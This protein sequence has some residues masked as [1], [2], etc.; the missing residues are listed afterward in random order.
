MSLDNLQ[1]PEILIAELYKN[2]LV[3]LT[4]D[5]DSDST[6]AIPVKTELKDHLQYL[7]DHLKRTCILVNYPNDLYIAESQLT[8]LANVL[9]A[10]SLTLADIA[11]INLAKQQPSI[12]LI[13]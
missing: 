2:N 11:I 8:F 4:E 7:G 5:N 3:A 9:K 1:L 6:T 13:R 12:S 10:C